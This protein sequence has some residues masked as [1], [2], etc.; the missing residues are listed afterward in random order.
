M[1][2]W[3]T[4]TITAIIIILF[5]AML[6]WINMRN[7]AKNSMRQA[8][9]IMQLHKSQQEQQTFNERLINQ[10]ERGVEKEYSGANFG[11][12]IILDLPENLRGMFHDL[13]K[14]FEDFAKLKGYN[15]AFS[16]DSSL[17]D[18]IA[19]KF[20]LLDEGIN[21]STNT[22]RQDI[23]EYIEKVKSGDSF[24]DLPVILSPAEHLLVSTT[25]KN[26]LSFLSHNY[27]LEKN[28]KEF[29]ENF[30][31]TLAASNYGIAQ[32]AP[33]YIQTG[34]NYNPKSLAA[35]NSPNSLLGDN[36]LYEN[37][38]DNSDHSVITITNSFNK[39]KEQ[40]NKL[41]EI[42]RLISEHKDLESS[43]KQTLITNFDKIKEELSDEEQP[44][45]SKIFK[46]LS[47][48][49]KILENVVLS[50]EAAQAIQWI[51]ETFKF[52]V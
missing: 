33:I 10:I 52:I 29:Y 11:G 25:L 12:Y 42:I 7:S 18:K 15:I 50:H 24:D 3:S 22:V 45:K 26:R 30:F 41:D 20:T 46:W 51:Y 1:E 38:S 5:V 43:Q 47:N 21:V 6:I 19:F 44:S 13:L 36:N 16:I 17:Q 37:N 4:V 34:G 27:N 32:Q 9:L 40:I 39:K 23:Y 2:I 35:I 28:A 31:K 8:E 48:T 14:G 49:K